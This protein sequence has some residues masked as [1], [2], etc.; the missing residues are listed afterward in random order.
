M[1]IEGFGGIHQ[2]VL[3]TTRQEN[4]LNENGLNK[5]TE[6]RTTWLFRSNFKYQIDAGTRLL[7]RLNHAESDSSLGTFFDGGYTE[8]VLGYGFRP[9]DNDRLN[10]LVKYTYFYNVPTTEQISVQSVASEFIQKTHIAAVDVTYDLS[11]NLTVGGKYAY[12]LAQISLDRET[13]DFFDNNASLYVLR[14]DYRFLDHYEF[15]A[16]GRMLS[17]SDIDER[18][19]GALLAVSRYLGDHLKIGA[20]YNFSDFSDDLTDLSYDHQGFFLSITGSM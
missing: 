19:V 8:A 10:A 2:G 13:V 4:R 9:V 14:G 16:E 12:R 15:L 6:V 1:L 17:M 11:P 3:N 7:G 18:R 20:G 5:S